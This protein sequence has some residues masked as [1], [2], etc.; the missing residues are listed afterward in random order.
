MKTKLLISITLAIFSLS[1]YAQ[2]PIPNGNFEN[3]QSDTYENPQNYPFTS[4]I[5]AFYYHN[6]PYNCIKIN[7]AYHGSHAV[8]L[9]TSSD[10]LFG[11]FININPGNTDIPFWHGGFPYSEQPTGLRGYYKSDI[12]T[13]D[14]AR[15][16]VNFSKNGSSLGFYQIGLYG[17]HN[18]YTLFEITFDPPLS[19]VPDSVIFG[20]ASSDVLNEN[21]IMG[22]MIII[23][24]VSFT[25]VSSQPA[26]FNGDFELWDNVNVQKLAEWYVYGDHNLYNTV[27]QTTDKVKGDYAVKLI[28][29]EGEQ[30]GNP[31]ARASSIS[32]GY[33]DNNCGCMKG[34]HTFTNQIDTLTFWYKYEPMGSDTASVN[35]IFK[36]NG[37][38]IFYH[39]VYL[40]AT[41]GTYQFVEVPFDC[42][43]SP[44]TVIIQIVTSLWHHNDP[45][46]IG[47]EL[48]IDEIAFKSQPLNTGILNNSNNT[49]SVYPNPSEGAFRITSNKKMSFIEIY[50]VKGQQIYS[51]A[52]DTKEAE[53]NL[54]NKAA[55]I[56]FYKI[57]DSDSGVRTGKLIIK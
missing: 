8:Q 39:T 43:Q 31:T 3:W 55:G 7:D 41:T 45:A 52:T 33:W 9:T 42:M 11:Y 34:G 22:S 49:I 27:V 29:Y 1:A 14:T 44:D 4:N 57:T 21:A 23:D 6:M 10:E 12:Q 53:I 13:G 51:M 47:S 37:N 32:T 30:Y 5:D 56:Y 36:Q 15:V 28:T 20:V 24:S 2:N 26:L 17:T 40:E 38:D 35:L 25:G 16:L 54:S 18:T 19:D 48:K 50:D 46:H